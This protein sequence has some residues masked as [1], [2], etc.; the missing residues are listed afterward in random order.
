MFQPDL[1]FFLTDKLANYVLKRFAWYL[2]NMSTIADSSMSPEKG[3]MPPLFPASQLG[4]LPSMDISAEL[5][6]DCEILACQAAKAYLNHG[7]Q[8]EPQDHQQMII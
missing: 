4:P 8:S 1:P 5:V 2:K 7:K 3:A 6:T